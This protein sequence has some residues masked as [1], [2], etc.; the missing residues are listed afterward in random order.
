MNAQMKNVVFIAGAG[1][2]VYYLYDQHQKKREAEEMAEFLNFSRKR[3]KPKR[4]V[5]AMS[6]FNERKQHSFFN[7]GVKHR[8][9]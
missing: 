1:L 8:A 6:G 4:P 9:F 2:I 3:R 7:N 5:R